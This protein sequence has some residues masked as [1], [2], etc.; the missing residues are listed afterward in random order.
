M[1]KLSIEKPVRVRFAPSPTGF[2]HIGGARTAI[3]NWAFA[4]R[5]GGTF[6]LR[7]EDTDPERSTPENTAQIIR[8]LRWLG[9]D[10]DE[11]PEVGGDFGP[12][13]QTERFSTYGMALKH[14]QENDLVYPCFCTPEELAARRESALS[15]QDF[16]GYDRSCR[17]LNAD[18][19]SARLTAGEPCAWRLK[20]PLEH[21]DI[22]FDDAVYGQI[23][24]PFSEM[25]DLICVRSDGSP[26]YNFA[27]VIDDSNMQVSH[28]IRGD[29]HLSNTPKQILIYEA[30][31]LEVPTFAHLS[32]ILGADGKRL[33]KRHG[34]TSIEAYRDE[35]YLSEALLNY[36]A[37][38][39]WS[40]DGKTDIFS[41]QTLCENFSFGRVSKNPATFDN[42][43]LTWV[44][45]TYIKE[46]GARA[47]IDALTP[48]LES[49]GL[50]YGIDGKANAEQVK[51]SIQ[52]NRDWYEAIYPLIAERA[53]T[54][55]D[56][57]P[58]VSYLFSG[59][60]LEMDE[61]S[62]Q[63]CLSAAEIPNLLESCITILDNPSLEW[64]HNNIE[65]ALRAVPEV[66][67]VK[68]KL[69]FQAVRVAICGN[70]VSPPLFESIELIGRNK[71][72][73]RLKKAAET[74]S[75]IAVSVKDVTTP[76]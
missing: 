23:T 2:L 34:A 11:G 14:L 18:E 4:R 44:N 58:M 35:G 48:W 29:D 43:K 21:D 47:F 25:D 72:L 26:T 67:G 68:P 27:A 45:S 71:A 17:H 52:D 33:S 76:S 19:V 9:L 70:M 65:A 39:G 75:T 51:D 15:K 61:K 64:Q 40:L 37:L 55:A 62:V 10:W 74:A 7:I 6:I 24:V 32:M 5:M 41:A 8:S 3:Y 56:A 13:L 42:D 73:A 31:G 57:A 22:V 53:K 49:A 30:L 38:L 28:V 66:A 54:L 20:L 60:E 12:Y 50:A 63:K 69:L 36:L 59:S 46:M 16:H 1:D